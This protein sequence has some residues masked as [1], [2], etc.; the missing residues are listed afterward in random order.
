M[1]ISIVAR[2][3]GLF[4]SGLAIAFAA[5]C[6]DGGTGR[7]AGDGG[8]DSTTSGDPTSTSSTGASSSA[9]GGGGSAPTTL[10]MIDNMEDGD[11]SIIADASRKGAWYTYNDE[12]VGAT[13]VPAVKTPFTM[14]AVSPPRDGSTV[15]AN[16]TGSGF[17]TWGAGFGFD[18]N[19]NG[20]TKSAY[21]ASAYKGVS[22]WAKIGAGSA[23][24]VRFN[25]GDKNTTPEAGVCAAGKCSDDF[26]KD[27]TLTGTW[28]K[29]DITFAEMKQVGWSTVILPAIEASGLYYVHF[30]AGAKATFDI[31]ID[32]IAFTQ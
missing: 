23:G 11:G 10:S 4:L 19:N 1:N 3:M 21:D 14:T 13:Q 18:L 30:Q 29:F 28:T 20:T 5:S 9:T 27:L 15:A 24:A 25:I 7:T 2:S 6:D 32:D 12:T 16:T 31:W 22:F 8:D 17:T 26:G